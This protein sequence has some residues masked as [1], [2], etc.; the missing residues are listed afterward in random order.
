M[1]N[2][3]LE[4]VTTKTKELLETPTCCQELKDMAQAWLNAIGTNQEKELTEK[5]IVELEEDLMLIDQLIE[6]SSSQAGEDYFGKELAKDI[7]A[8]AKEIKEK[9]S[10][11]CDC[12]ACLVVADI[13]E[14]KDD[15]LG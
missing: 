11:Y 1:N 9:G 13:L 15:I 2:D 8:H 5:Y 3:I 10:Q 12:P 7:A 6:F 4:Y 14:K